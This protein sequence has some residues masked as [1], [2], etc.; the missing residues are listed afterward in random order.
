MYVRRLVCKNVRGFEEIDLDLCPMYEAPNRSDRRKELAALSAVDGLLAPDEPTPADNPF[1]GWT[2]ITGDNGSGKS[3]V[4]KSIALALLGPE[5]ARSLIQSYDGWVTV[6][7]KRGE[8]SLEIRPDASID[9]TRAGG[10]PYKDTFWAEIDV[11]MDEDQPGGAP[12]IVSPSDHFKHKKLGA[13]TGPWQLATAG[14]LGIGYGPFR[15]LYGSSPTAAG[16]EAD[17][18]KA[19]FATLFMEDATLREAEKWLQDLD[20]VSARASTQDQQRRAGAQLAVVQEILSADFL[21]NGMTFDRVDASGVW[22]KDADRRHLRLSDMSEGYRAALAMLIDIVRH[23]FLCYDDA[24]DRVHRDEQ[25]RV[26]LKAPAVVIID[27]IDAHLHPAWQR[28]IGPWLTSH[29][30]LIQFI[31]T[32][33]SP[34]VCQAAT[35][36]RIYVLPSPGSS[37]EPRRV[38][39]AEYEHLLAADTD[40]VL[41]SPAFQVRQPRPPRVIRAMK[42]HAELQQLALFEVEVP[43]EARAADELEQL[44]LFFEGRLTEH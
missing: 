21:R 11:H 41:A 13:Q 37:D 36:G 25:G 22:L 15:R 12:W 8:I 3:T 32:T 2:V 5:K 7:Q 29:F 30:P 28:E 23:L 1:P 33:H 6:G 19:R 17:P 24:I 34:L 26:S 10:H 20:Y 16:L 35:G 27:E 4:L 31:V 44:E 14:W 43:A 9:K 40:E 18:I 42:R 38:T 39:A